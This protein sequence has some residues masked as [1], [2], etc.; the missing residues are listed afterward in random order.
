MIFK[1]FSVYDYKAQTYTAPF[2][3]HSEARAIRSFADCAQDPEHQFGK[4][5]ED[6]TLFNL[7]EFDDTLASITQDKIT[8]VATA[9][10]LVQV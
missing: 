1:I 4:H 6:Y 5:P 2:F 8:S 10:S 3:D 9:L 7:S